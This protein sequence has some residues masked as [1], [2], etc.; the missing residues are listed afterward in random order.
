MNKSKRLLSSAVARIQTIRK[1]SI[2]VVSAGAMLVGSTSSAVAIDGVID[3][4]IRTINC[5]GLLFTDPEL[6][7]VECGVGDT[8]NSGTLAPLI[9]VI[10]PPPP[11]PPTLVCG[12]G[13]TVHDH[14]CVSTSPS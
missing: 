9:F 4:T 1:I 7:L 14:E 3:E 13:E 8:S 11:P 10:P 2:G 6:H 12:D 5:I